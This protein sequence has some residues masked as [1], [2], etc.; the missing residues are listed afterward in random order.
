MLM[1]LAI[2]Y[3]SSF[4]KYT[5]CYITNPDRINIAYSAYPIHLHWI[6]NQYPLQSIDTM[7]PPLLLELIS[8]TI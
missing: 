3:W 1:L 5:P 8:L 2:G 7:T 6:L 4:Q